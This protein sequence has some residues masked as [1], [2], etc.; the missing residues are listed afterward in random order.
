MA[1][2]KSRQ[3]ASDSWIVTSPVKP[4]SSFLTIRGKKF[5]QYRIIDLFDQAEKDHQRCA[6]ACDRTESTEGGTQVQSVTEQMKHEIELI[7]SGDG[8]LTRVVGVL[9]VLETLVQ[10]GLALGAVECVRGFV[11][12]GKGRI[13]FALQL[14]APVKEVLKLMKPITDPSRVLARRVIARHEAK[15]PIGGH[16]DAVEA[17]S[18][19]VVKMGF[20]GLGRAI[21]GELHF[22]HGRALRLNRDQDGLMAGK[23]LIAQ[24]QHHF[25]RCHRERRRQ[26]RTVV[27]EAFT[28][29]PHGIGLVLE[30]L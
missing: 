12:L 19:Q 17:M 15:A 26:R 16:A 23:N 20:P 5:R 3:G 8:V 27:L 14:A 22:Q 11:L 10:M 28:E 25:V 2:L 7:V 29:I 21:R 18:T 24:I 30:V 13:G 6:D 9:I 4:G 1:Q